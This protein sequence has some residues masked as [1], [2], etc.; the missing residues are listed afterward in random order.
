MLS[1]KMQLK[2][3]FR[4][5][6][7]IN[8]QRDYYEILELTRKATQK[9]IKASFKRL[10]KIYHP[11]VY[12]GGDKTKYNNILKAY[13]VL[14]N[15]IKR[16]DYD[17]TL[18]DMDQKT[19]FDASKYHTHKTGTT[20]A[21]KDMNDFIFSEAGFYS[22]ENLEKEVQKLKNKRISTKFEKIRFAED[23]FTRQLSDKEKERMEFVRDYNQ[24]DKTFR[25][26]WSTKWS[27]DD[28]VKDT[29]DINN[30]RVNDKKKKKWVNP[31][32]KYISKHRLFSIL[33]MGSFIVISIAAYLIYDTKMY[34]RKQ[35]LELSLYHKDIEDEIE[36]K[37]VRKRFIYN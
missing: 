4:F 10:T 34:Y 1:A 25:D 11:D 19:D 36:A 5:F 27:Y 35:I 16:K 15:P 13:G 7:S 12:K 14:K 28:S 6:S 2:I 8:G 29:I 20:G 23:P 18:G 32:Y 37:K 21:N 3:A 24:T 17:I 31:L 33:T 22:K 30:N 9:E 26:E